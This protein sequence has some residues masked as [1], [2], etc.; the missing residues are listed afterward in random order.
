[1]DLTQQLTVHIG[2]YRYVQFIERI[3]LG[4]RTVGERHRGI[5]SKVHSH[6]EQNFQ[7]RRRSQYTEYIPRTQ[8][9]LHKRPRNRA[10]REEHLRERR[11][12]SK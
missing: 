5:M 7:K 8:T 2:L 12:K 4:E 9:S 6:M 11:E 10:E 3:S 1:M